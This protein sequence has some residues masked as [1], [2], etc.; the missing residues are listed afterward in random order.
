ME[1]NSLSAKLKEIKAVTGWSEPR[2]AEEIG[3]SQPTVNRILHGQQDCK[4]STWQRITE[5]HSRTVATPE[6]E[7]EKSKSRRK[8]VIS[9]P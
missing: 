8:A 6:S 9:F 2:I 7:V 4:A 3:S 1:T 5:L